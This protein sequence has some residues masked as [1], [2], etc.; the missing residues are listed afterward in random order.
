MQKVITP[1]IF[2]PLSVLYMQ[3]PQKL[4]HLRAGP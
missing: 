3:Q 2:V 1:G 4:D